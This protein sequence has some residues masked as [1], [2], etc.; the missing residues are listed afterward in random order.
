MYIVYIITC[1][2]IV[3]NYIH[4]TN[5]LCHLAI[6]LVTQHEYR[7]AIMSDSSTNQTSI[8]DSIISMIIALYQRPMHLDQWT[9]A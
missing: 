1:N 9:S 6:V 2:V 5:L 4:D 7:S 3:F 8:S